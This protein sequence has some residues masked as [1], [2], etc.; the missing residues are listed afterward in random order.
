MSEVTEIVQSATD[1]SLA[2]PIVTDDTPAFLK[3]DMEVI[4]NPYQPF[5]DKFFPDGNFTPEQMEA[6]CKNLIEL[7]S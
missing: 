4:A 5:L 1:S 2:H 7:L 6:L 3:K